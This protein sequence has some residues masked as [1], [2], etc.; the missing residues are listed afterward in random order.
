MLNPSHEENDETYSHG[1]PALPIGEAN[2]RAYTQE[3]GINSAMTSF[4]RRCPPSTA[5]FISS[6]VLSQ[7][8][9]HESTSSFTGAIEQPLSSIPVELPP[10]ILHPTS[11]STDQMVGSGPSYSTALTHPYTGSRMIGRIS[12]TNPTVGTSTLHT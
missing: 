6:P 11:C 5:R 2:C 3:T 4:S 8:V 1:Q 10:P 9:R 12:S 7:A